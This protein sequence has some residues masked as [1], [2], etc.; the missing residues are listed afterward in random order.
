MRAQV[1]FIPRRQREERKDRER[2]REREDELRRK[3]AVKLKNQEFLESAVDYVEEK[4]SEYTRERKT[5]EVNEKEKEKQRGVFKF[6]WDA[7]E[8]T[9]ALAEELAVDNWKRR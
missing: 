4:P 9:T 5:R 1:K 2:E 6:D 8:D 7:K 3:E